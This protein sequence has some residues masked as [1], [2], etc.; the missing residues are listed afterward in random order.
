[1]AL[2][3]PRI[4]IAADVG[5]SYVLDLNDYD[6]TAGMIILGVAERAPLAFVE[7]VFPRVLKIVE[8]TAIDEDG[9]VF[10]RT[11]SAPSLRPAI[12][13]SEAVIQGLENGLRNL[14][15]KMPESLEKL[16]D[17]YADTRYGTIAFLMLRA[18][19]ANPARFAG[20]I[21]EFLLGHSDRLDIGYGSP[22]DGNGHAAVSR[23]AISR[24]APYLD[25]ETLQRLENAIIG[26]NTRWEYENPSFQG[27]TELLLLHALGEARLSIRG[28]DRFAELQRKYPDVDVSMPSR[29]S[30]SRRVGGNPISSAE[31][32]KLSDDEWL[33]AMAEHSANSRFPGTDP[34]TG[35]AF[36]LSLVLAQQVRRDRSRFAELAQRM[37]D[38][39]NPHYFNAIL[40]G[41]CGYINQSK[42]ERSTDDRDFERFPTDALLAVIRQLHALPRRP[43]GKAVCHAFERI[44]GREIPDADLAILQHYALEDRDPA[45]DDWLAPVGPGGNA[46]PPQCTSM[47]I[48]QFEAVRQER[49]HHCYSP[50]IVG[51]P[52]SCPCSNR[53]SKILHSR[54]GHAS[55]RDFYLSSTI[56]DRK[57]SNCLWTLAR[58]LTSSSDLVHLKNL[59]GT[60]PVP[61]MPRYVHCFSAH[62][63]RLMRRPSPRV[64]VRFV[65]PRFP[66]AKPRKTRAVCVRVR[67]PCG[68]ELPRSMRTTFLIQKSAKLARRIF[69]GCSGMIRQKCAT[70]QRTA[71]FTLTTTTLSGM[72]T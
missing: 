28:K 68:S 9:L 40:E 55:L 13:T 22:D 32:E 18:W 60:R 36:E 47:A 67:R 23:D 59:C 25:L 54:C 72:R 51:P 66:P 65:W 39:L 71:S 10:D 27:W 46:K 16:L 6:Q 56:N 50:T 15:G 7:H 33:V 62:S 45:G 48:T 58:G 61:I 8:M 69:C 2:A 52:S 14:A 57:V 20:R 34:T 3:G 30:G 44:G 5:N 70:R 42:E 41:L 64:P 29:R 43:C 19:S 26:Y 63:S 37:D 12:R 17:P 49:S 21:T 38:G 31:T 11:W 1:M 35:G 4:R 53:W 24:A